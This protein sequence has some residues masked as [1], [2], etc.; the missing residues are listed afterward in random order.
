MESSQQS[1]DTETMLDDLISYMMD[2]QNGNYSFYFITRRNG[3]NKKEEENV[4]INSRLFYFLHHPRIVKIFCSPLTMFRLKFGYINRLE[5]R[6]VY[7]NSHG[8][9]FLRQSTIKLLKIFCTPLTMFGLKFSYIN[10]LIICFKSFLLLF[11]FSYR[12]V[13]S[14]AEFYCRFDR[15]ER[16]VVTTDGSRRQHGHL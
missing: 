2:Q 16:I 14:I 11:D 8:F 4:Y 12:F 5:E 3:D 1:V 6:K 15:C 10:R 9:Y 13:R 7:I